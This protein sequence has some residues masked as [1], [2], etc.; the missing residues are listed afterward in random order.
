MRLMGKVAL[1]TGAGGGFGEG[2][3]RAGFHGGDEG[4]LGAV[5]GF[6]QVAQQL[7]RGADEAAALEAPDAGGEV[8]MA[9]G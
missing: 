9:H 4:V 1:V 7:D 5:L 3:A 2:I 8:G 6:V